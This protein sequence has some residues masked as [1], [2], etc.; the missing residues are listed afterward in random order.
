MLVDPSGVSSPSTADTPIS[1]SEELDTVHPLR[2]ELVQLQGS[3]LIRCSSPL[4]DA[5]G[6]ECEQEA[7]SDL[8]VGNDDEAGAAG[9]GSARADGHHLLRLGPR[10]SCAGMEFLCKLFR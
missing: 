7:T 1:R 10:L 4:T 3:R 8:S 9:E 2:S 6:D 5:S